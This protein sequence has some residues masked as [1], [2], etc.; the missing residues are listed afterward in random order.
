MYVYM[1]FRL[2]QQR[3]TILVGRRNNMTWNVRFMLQYGVRKPAERNFLTEASPSCY[4]NQAERVKQSAKLLTAL[5]LRKIGNSFL[6]FQQLLQILSMVQYNRCF[7]CFSKI[8]KSDYQFLY[9]S[10]CPSVPM[11]KLVS[12]YT[13]FHEF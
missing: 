4:I 11:E 8:A 5:L 7:R 10:L 13:D 3:E 1:Q 9:V 6:S 12:H 2:W